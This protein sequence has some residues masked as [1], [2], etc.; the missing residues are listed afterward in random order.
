VLAVLASYGAAR[1]Q[2]AVVSTSPALNQ[3]V[4]VG[5]IVSVE[6]D[7]PLN[8][9]T[10]NADTFRVFGRGSGTVTG[11]YS[12]SNGNRTVTLTPNAPFTAG[13]FVFVNL[14]HDLEGADSS[15]LRA[16]GYAFQFTTRTAVSPA[17]FQEIDTFSNRTGGS[18]G[19][20]T[21]IYGAAATDLNNDE[22]L[23]LATVNEV[24]ADVRVF[25]NLADGS[26]LYGSMLAP[27]PIGVESSPNEPADFDNDGK[28]DL[29]TA[30]ASSGSISILL[31]AGNGNFSSSQEIDV[32]DAPHGIAPLDVDGD[33][34]LDIVNANV[35][36]N[37]LSLMLNDGSG[38]FG[39]PTFFEGGVN[40]EYGLTQADM[41]GDG[42][43]DLVVAGRNG[44]QIVTLLGNGNG[45]F[46]AAG[47]AQATGGNTW[48]VVVGDV[49]GDGD[50]DAVTANDGSGT[51]G[52]LLGLGDGTFAAVST[53][54]IGSH[55]PS[56]DLGD[57]DGDN[58]LD[59][60]VS[61]FG[62]GF[63]R[64]FENDGTGSFSSVEEIPA[65]SNPS[66]SILLDFDNDGDLDMALTDEIA[67]V[68][69][70]ME[71]GGSGG[72]SACTPGPSA[73]RAPVAA[74]KSKLMLTDRSPNDR[75][76]L[77]W[78]WRGEATSIADYGNPLATEGYDL[79]LYRDGAL[80][81]GFE[82]PA[83]G[84]CN[85]RACWKA[86]P[87]GFSYRDSELTPDGVF[88]GMLSEGLVD[89]RA[90]IRIAG[91]GTRLGMPD[92][93]DLDGTL[94][95]QLQKKSDGLCWG[96]RFSQPFRKDDGVILQAF[97]DAPDPATPDPIWSAIHAQVVGPVCGGCH[98]VGSSGGLTGLNVCDTA[99]ANLVDVA[100]TELTTMDRVEPGDATISW[101]MHKLD[102][103]HI[104]FTAQCQS[105]FCGSQMPLGGELPLNT[106][107]AIRA[108]ITNGAANDCP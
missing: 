37:N 4:A 40:G 5:S 66:C 92:F 82:V 73:C 85:G 20:Q 100:S 15:S 106:R 64:R 96:A 43:T 3:N 34:D 102:G 10:V 99:H 103:T 23:D 18:G 48:V 7:R 78:S 1:A 24:S 45:T 87:K 65:P 60:V 74:F 31:G 76:R 88:S 52:V 30:A 69:V 93:D 22:Y 27:E 77:S 16:E 89:G 44:A 11:A 28:T 35:D 95:V 80:V 6:F 26:G 90:S 81:Q 63:W 67:D 58:D 55:V 17:N 8:L 12:F 53:I 46:T 29:C 101:L 57:L 107:N 13:E 38:V 75:D 21:R 97:S 14:S 105:G 33:G 62:G 70:L 59:M 108:W 61:S 19:P 68:V 50:L 32:G 2:L 39:A 51:I 41:D 71:N 83:A 94:E 49:N 98:G 86:T 36:S 54:N 104:W 47:T 42:I 91:R 25:L 84:V 56:V 9:T 72:G 79:C